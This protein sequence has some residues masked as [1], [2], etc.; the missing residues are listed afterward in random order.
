MD[1]AHE[2]SEWLRG[3]SFIQTRPGGLFPH[4]IAREVL[5]ADLRWRN[6]GWYG[7]LHRR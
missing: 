4:D 2:P 1:D 5:A 7:E 6:P 3:L